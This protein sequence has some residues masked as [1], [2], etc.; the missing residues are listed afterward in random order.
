MGQVQLG[1]QQQQI[2]QP[3]QQQ[4]GQLQWQ[5]TQAA[6]FVSPEG[7]RVAGAPMGVINQQVLLLYL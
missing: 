4:P 6:H 3:A 7:V 2:Q 5:Q 1:Q